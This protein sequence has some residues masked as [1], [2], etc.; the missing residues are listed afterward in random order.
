MHITARVDYA[1]QAMLVLA[2]SETTR[3]PAT[4]LADTL[5]V[6]YSYL[7]TVVNELRK[8]RLVRRL[9]GPQGGLLLAKPASA[10]TLDQIVWAIDGPLT[11]TD[12]TQLDSVRCATRTGYLPSLWF[13]A[14]QAMLEVFS[15]VRL[16]DATFEHLP[17][18]VRDL[19]TTPSR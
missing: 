12:G 2:H 14:H 5:G 7:H 10:I 19:L 4:E 3:I 9:R 6:S 16:A 13:A 17:P 8:A 15:Q 11:S 18:A 1:I